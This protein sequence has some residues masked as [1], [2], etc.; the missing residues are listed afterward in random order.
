MGN[1][2]SGF[3]DFLKYPATLY[4]SL[5]IWFS[6]SAGGILSLVSLSDSLGVG[7]EK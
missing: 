7:G 5:P 4:P 2:E 3:F 6:A 1:K